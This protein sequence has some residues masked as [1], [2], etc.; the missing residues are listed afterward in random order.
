MARPSLKIRLLSTTLLSMWLIWAAAGAMIYSAYYRSLY[1]QMDESL[2]AHAQALQAQVRFEPPPKAHWRDTGGVLPPHPEDDD[3]RDVSPPRSDQDD[4]EVERYAGQAPFEMDRNYPSRSKGRRDGGRRSKSQRRQPAGDASGSEDHGPNWRPSLELFR[5]TEA[6]TPGGRQTVEDEYQV[7]KLPNREIVAESPQ[8]RD[9]DL[10][11]DTEGSVVYDI[12]LADGRKARAVTMR[13]HVSASGP[14]HLPHPTSDAVVTVARPTEEMRKDLA[15]MVRLIAAAGLIGASLIAIAV[16]LSIRF[17][18][19]P[20]SQLENQ[21]RAI[22]EQNLTQRVDA[23]TAP[24][25]IAGMGERINDLLERLEGAFDR[26]R[27]FIADAAHELRTPIT[28]L[29]ATTELA[30]SQERDPEEYQKLLQRN[31]S[32]L[33]GVHSLLEKLFLLARL[34]NHQ[35][36]LQSEKIDLHEVVENIWEEVTLVAGRTDICWDNQ[37]LTSMQPETDV[38]LICVI[39]SNLLR[40]AAEHVDEHGRVMVQTVPHAMGWRLFVSNTGCTLSKDQLSNIFDRFWQGDENRSSTGKNAG[41]GLAITKRAVEILGGKI[42]VRKTEGER[43][44][45]TVEV[46]TFS[47]SPPVSSKRGRRQAAV[48]DEITYRVVRPGVTDRKG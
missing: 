3:D 9:A 25:E 48:A 13:F 22:G 28:A 18:L 26:E 32:V 15:E 38:D 41:L 31:A 34:D 43:I 19:A 12:V 27:G 7:L 6:Y 1:E 2:F 33:E 14:P 40:N 4:K 10:Q 20:V 17:S 5:Q 24:V 44:V 47:S 8:L 39:I 35:V 11:V 23:S 46:P 30:L 16:G 45:F 21:I 42:Y 36:S 29:K 37:V